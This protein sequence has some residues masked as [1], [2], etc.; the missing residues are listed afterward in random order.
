M[1][2]K[3]EKMK[4]CLFCAEDIQNDAI[5]CKHCGSLG[6]ELADVM[7]VGVGRKTGCGDTCSL[8]PSV[9]RET[10]TTTAHTV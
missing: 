6:Q 5:K 10:P 3:L 1:G 8:L 9:N 7:Q 4:K 2:F